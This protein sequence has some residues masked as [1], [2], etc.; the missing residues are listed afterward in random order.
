LA[1]ALE[2]KSK[3]VKEL[4]LELEEIRNKKVETAT[5]LDVIKEETEEKE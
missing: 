2:L 3:E 1:K 5:V 4:S